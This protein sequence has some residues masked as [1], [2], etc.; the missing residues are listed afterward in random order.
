MIYEDLKNIFAIEIKSSKIKK[1]KDFS[2]INKLEEEFPLKKKII[3]C[4]A[5]HSWIEDN[6]IEVYC[7]DNFL[8]ILQVY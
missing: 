4:L 1:N 5:Q 2:G 8:L 7:V 3:V 6:G